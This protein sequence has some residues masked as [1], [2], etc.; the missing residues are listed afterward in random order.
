[1]V[2]H[3]LLESMAL[4]SVAIWD[5]HVLR[6]A[7]ATDASYHAFAGSR[8]KMAALREKLIAEGVDAMSIFGGDHER[9]KARAARG[10]EFRRTAMVDGARQR[11]PDSPA[12]ILSFSF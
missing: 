6:A 3:R 1:M 8:R 5:L 9:A 12:T 2:N 4:T 7:V 11:E 10:G